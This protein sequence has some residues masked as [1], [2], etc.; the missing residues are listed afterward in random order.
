MKLNTN[1][2]DDMKK[3]KL[4]FFKSKGYDTLMNYLKSL[5]LKYIE[6]QDYPSKLGVVLGIPMFEYADTIISHQELLGR[7]KQLGQIL[8]VKE[9]SFVTKE[10]KKVNF[11]MAGEF[12]IQ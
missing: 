3:Y 4:S 11:N 5:I 7:I 9:I 6:L 2:Q 8:G 12:T 10:G 1:N